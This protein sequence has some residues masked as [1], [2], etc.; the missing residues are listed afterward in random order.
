MIY[1]RVMVHASELS[2]GDIT[3]SIVSRV[4]VLVVWPEPAYGV[5]NRSVTVNYLVP[6]GA[7]ERGAVQA[8]AYMRS[9]VLCR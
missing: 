9:I 8:N 3:M 6:H 2:A 7:L 5:L 4:P 1:A